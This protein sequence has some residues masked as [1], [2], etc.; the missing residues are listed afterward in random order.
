MSEGTAISADAPAKIGPGRLVLVVGPS[1]AGKDTLL[2]LAQAA[3]T[4]DTGIVFPRRVVTR[5]ASSSEDNDYLSVDAFQHALARGEF[6]LHW[7][8]HGHCYGV[9]R[10]LDDDIRVG[11][12]VVVN[13]SRTIIDAA[14][15]AYTETVVVL[16]TAPPAILAERLAMRGRDSDGRIEARLGR[17]V[18]YA[19][20]DVTIVNVGDAEAHAR[21]MVNAIRSD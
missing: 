2:N 14:R 1:G 4:G 17:A 16:V 9:P 5:E 19:G 20:P 21:R 13:V 12:T 3:C 18:E 8:A 11:R 15:R 6:S 10:A 7:E